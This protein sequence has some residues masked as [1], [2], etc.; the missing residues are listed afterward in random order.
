[1][2]QDE[3]NYINNFILKNGERL[4]L[5]GAIQSDAS[6]VEI[7]IVKQTERT[8]RVVG[9]I[10]LVAN[11]LIDSKMVDEQLSTFTPRKKLHLNEHEPQTLKWFQQGFIMKEFR[12][13]KDGKTVE[14]QYYRMGYPLYKFLKGQLR[15]EEEKIENEFNS[16]K[17]TAST[18]GQICTKS[19][20]RE[21]GYQACL[22]MINEICQISSNELKTAAQFPAGWSFAK[23]LKFLHFM[24][25]F[26]QLSFQKDEFDWKEIGASYYQKI[27]GSKEFDRYKDDYINLL[28]QWASWPVALLGMA[29]LGKITPLYFSG[30][31][32]GHFSSYRFGP[33]HSLTDLAISEERYTTDSTTLWLVENRAILTRMSAKKNFLEE[34]NSLVI[35]VDGHLRSSHKHCIQQL[36]AGGRVKQVL[37]WSDYDPDG[38]QIAKEAYLTVLEKFAGTIKWIR[39]DSNVHTNWQEYETYMEFLLKETKIEQEQ[40]L[41][42]V[43]E[44]KKWIHQ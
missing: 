32:S 31:I 24:N 4:D 1:M 28:E 22:S 8:Y 39:H 7:K 33:V 16:W 20:Q 40:V 21:S 17:K 30:Q 23:R 43:E 29:S 10:T 38:F 25:A 19:N 9:F 27:G 11:N 3:I 41:G 42:G 26:W 44:W 12:F 18:L 5:T 6:F 13:K 2:N 36:L 14:S 37:I 34:T 15:A 35:C